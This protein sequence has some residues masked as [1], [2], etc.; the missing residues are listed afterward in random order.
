MNNTQKLLLSAALAAPL[1]LV[2]CGGDS[3][4]TTADVTAV[5]DSAGASVESFLAF[6]MSLSPDDETSEPLTISDNFAVPDDESSE[7]QP[8]A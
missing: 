3:H 4:R 8:L 7:P 2:G 6:I 5:P 1:A